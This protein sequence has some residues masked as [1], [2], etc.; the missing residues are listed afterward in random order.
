MSN[1]LVSIEI[2]DNWN[3]LESAMNRS[4]LKLHLRIFAILRSNMIVGPLL[5]DHCRPTRQLYV[6][7]I[8]KDPY[9]PTRKLYIRP[10]VTNPWC[11]T[12]KLY[13]ESSH[14]D[15][16]HPKR[17]YDCCLTVL[18]P[19]SRKILCMHMVG[20]ISEM[21]SKVRLIAFLCFFNTSNNFSS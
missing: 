10:L 19:S 11:L 12:R 7:P 15:P 16:C 6:G 1:Y 8:L 18:A 13:D 9:C 2:H 20:L 14:K 4:L 3:H 21:L 5:K 17:Q